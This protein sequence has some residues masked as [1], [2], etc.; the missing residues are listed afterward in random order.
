MGEVKTTLD[1]AS[2]ELLNLVHFA[3]TEFKDANLARKFK[4]MSNDVRKF[5]NDLASMIMEVNERTSTVQPVQEELEDEHENMLSVA[6]NI[7]SYA[8][9]EDK[10]PEKED[11][12]SMM[13]FSM[14]RPLKN[15]SL[16]AL[17]EAL[18]TMDELQYNMTKEFV[19]RE[20]I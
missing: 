13:L 3:S 8:L 9:R 18:Q 6:K 7:K 17:L 11:K 14:K 19:E 15:L 10:N 2:D 4:D 16:F 5:K 20:M 1:T 12:V